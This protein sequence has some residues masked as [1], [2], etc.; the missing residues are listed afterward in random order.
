LFSHEAY[1]F[2]VSSELL[3]LNDYMNGD[4]SVLVRAAQNFSQSLYIIWDKKQ[5]WEST[6]TP[7]PANLLVWTDLETDEVTN[8]TLKLLGVQDD[9]L[10]D[11]RRSR[12]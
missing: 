7:N 6:D 10:Y 1:L 11:Q 8:K 2:L 5:L 9:G 12:K 4:R 3:D